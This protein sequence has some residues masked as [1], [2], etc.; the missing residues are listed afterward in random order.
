MKTLPNFLCI[1]TQKAGTSWLYE[2][3]R[4]HPNIW[5]PPI[6]EL[7]YFD[8]IYCESSSKWSKWHIK[9]NAKRIIKHELNSSKTT[10]FEYIRYLASLASEPMLTEAWY[11]KA[12]DRPA[13]KNKVVGDITPEYCQIGDEGIAYLKSLLTDVKIL[14]IIR[15]PYER[16][17]SQLRMN[18]E[19]KSI[20]EDAPINT[21]M[22]LAR[23]PEIL[24]RGNY[25]DYIPRW[26]AQFSR[27]NLRYIPFKHIAEQ[28]SHILQ[29]VEDFIGVHNWDGYTAP[30][31][32]IHATHPFNLP[33]ETK[34]YL[35]EQCQPQ[36]DFLKRHFDADF[37]NAI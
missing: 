6:K 8:H 36:Y 32:K 29:N 13:A 28:A 20:H 2:Q 14:W 30:E 22:E 4:Q 34:A 33:E 15:D 35:Q 31:K 17:L 19:R 24:N 9:Q 26:E 27:N 12:F 16:A 21:W 1:G 3:L 11:E 23:S 18:A 7:H 10:Y 37:V 5:M 25:L